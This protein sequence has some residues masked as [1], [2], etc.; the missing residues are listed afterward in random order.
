[1]FHALMRY[2]GWDEQSKQIRAATQ[3]NLEEADAKL[4]EIQHRFEEFSRVSSS[5]RSA[6]NKT[7]TES[8]FGGRRRRAHR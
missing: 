5:D 3:K 2:L 6:L 4:D 7:L 1:M 8:D